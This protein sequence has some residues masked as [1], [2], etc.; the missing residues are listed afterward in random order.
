MSFIHL[1][2]IDKLCFF[3]FLIVFFALRRNYK[4]TVY[5]LENCS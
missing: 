3:E 5:K 4:F 1:M 2:L